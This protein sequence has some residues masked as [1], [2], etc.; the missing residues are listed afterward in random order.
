MPRPC[1]SHGRRLIVGQPR[2]MIL[3]IDPA[4]RGLDLLM[5]LATTSPIEKS[6]AFCQ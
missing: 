3:V 1:Q 4:A 6:F 5:Q 2:G